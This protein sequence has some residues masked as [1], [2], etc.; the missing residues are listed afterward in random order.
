MLVA[1]IRRYPVKSMLG[2]QLPEATITKRGIPGDRALALVDRESGKVASA[3]HPRRWRQLLACRAGVVALEHDLA[4]IS[5]TFPDG[6]TLLST[7]SAIDAALSELFDREVTLASTPPETAET[8]R[9]YP[10]VEGLPVSGMF[11]SGQIGLGAPPG[12][13]FDYAPIHLL[14]TATLAHL[15]ALTPSGDVDLRRFRPNLVI[16]TPGVTGFVENDWVGR[17]L[18]IGDDIRLRIT[19]PTPRCVIPTLP[20]GTLPR[21]PSLLRT[22]AAHNRPPI[23]TLGNVTWPS[24]GVYAT[25]EQSGVVREGDGVRVVG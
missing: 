14:T 15:G 22:I 17:T 23:P 18:L 3:K 7:D 20:H 9:D 16:N 2:E 13:F 12:T 11:F 25:V 8:E 6:R 4:T 1:T 24:I 10:E 21:D 19:D 5:I